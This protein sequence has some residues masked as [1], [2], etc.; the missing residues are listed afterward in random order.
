MLQLTLAVG[1]AD[2]K[3]LGLGLAL[4]DIGGGIPDPAAVAAYVGR[5]LHVGNNCAPLSIVSWF[6]Y[7]QSYRSGWRR[8]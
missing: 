7:Q 8:P 6:P 2:S 3:R 4:A 5:K 1:E